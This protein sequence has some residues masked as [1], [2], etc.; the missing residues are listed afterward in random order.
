MAHHTASP[1]L[2][3]WEHPY[4][5]CSFRRT[6]F[7]PP[8]RLSGRP[9]PI[10]WLGL[11]GCIIVFLHGHRSLD[12]L[13]PILTSTPVLVKKGAQSHAAIS[14]GSGTCPPAAACRKKYVWMCSIQFS[15]NRGDAGPAVFVC[16]RM[17]RTFGTAIASL[18]PILACLGDSG[19]VKNVHPQLLLTVHGL[20]D[21]PIPDVERNNHL[22]E[23]MFFL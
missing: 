13:H 4:T 19:S 7:Q 18:L 8:F 2:P 6:G 14:A 23:H 5:A 17:I 15:R 10:R 1:A 12:G 20:T 16:F 21:L 9:L 3:A 22:L 11:S